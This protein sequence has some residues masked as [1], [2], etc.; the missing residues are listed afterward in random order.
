MAGLCPRVFS[1]RK[2]TRVSSGGRLTRRRIYLIG[3]GFELRK[4]VM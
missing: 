3:F 4:S 2:I 1:T